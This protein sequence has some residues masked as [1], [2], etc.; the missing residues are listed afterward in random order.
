M[1][2]LGE[3]GLMGRASWSDQA[4]A[5]L[6]SIDSAVRDQLRRNA[7]EL[8]DIPPNTA[9]PADEGANGGIMWRRGIGDG[10][11]TE[12]DNGP[13]NYFLLYRKQ[14]PAPGFEILAVC[15]IH[16]MASMWAQMTREPRDG[17]DV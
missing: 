12:Q 10:R 6:Q 14:N 1:R 17:Y 3:G 4:E 2:R 7:E 11:S 8:Q 13:Q 15:S 5:D 9:D 16:Q